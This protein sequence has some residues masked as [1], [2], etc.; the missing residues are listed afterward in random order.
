MDHISGV[1]TKCTEECA[2]SVH[3]L[4]TVSIVR[5]I[6]IARTM[7]PNFWSDSRSSL[8]ASVWNLLSHKYREVLIGL[9]GSKSIL[10]LRSFPSEVMISPQ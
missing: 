2:V 1:T 3:D 7:K 8:R 4:E 9:K 10:I 5:W 6:G